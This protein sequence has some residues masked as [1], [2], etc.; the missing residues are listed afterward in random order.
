MGS[1]LPSPPYNPD[2]IS[3][4]HNLSSFSFHFLYYPTCQILNLRPSASSSYI[5][6]RFCSPHRTRRALHTFLSGPTILKQTDTGEGHYFFNIFLRFFEQCWETP[7]FVPQEKRTTFLRPRRVTS[8]MKDLFYSSPDPITERGGFFLQTYHPH[9]KT[10][11]NHS[12][13]DIRY[14]EQSSWPCGR[15][16]GKSPPGEGAWPRGFRIWV[17]DEWVRSEV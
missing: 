5:A 11:S 6:P 17:G 4:Y 14:H 8:R 13:D 16:K 12:Q 7:P 2:L 9:P 15:E 10:R 1:S 3:F